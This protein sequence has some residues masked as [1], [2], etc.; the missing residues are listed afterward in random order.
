MSSKELEGKLNMHSI[1][2][3]ISD[4]PA[5]QSTIADRVSVSSDEAFDPPKKPRELRLCRRKAN[6]RRAELKEQLAKA[7]RRKQQRPVTS[8]L[9]PYHIAQLP[10]PLRALMRRNWIARKSLHRLHLGLSGRGLFH[11]F[12]MPE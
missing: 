8:K 10:N 6:K 7:N 3:M 5:N 12:A 4:I 1:P 9:W 2:M 11:G